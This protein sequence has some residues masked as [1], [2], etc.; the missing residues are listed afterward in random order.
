[1]KPAEPDPETEDHLPRR[2]S[3]CVDKL[4]AH[5]QDSQPLEISHD[6]FKYSN[7]SGPELSELLEEIENTFGLQESIALR[8]ELRFEKEV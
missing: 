5:C 8:D 4:S 2:A 6:C 3:P 7:I 1:M